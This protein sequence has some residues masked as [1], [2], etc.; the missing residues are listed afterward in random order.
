MKGRRS[1]MPPDAHGGATVPPGR[2]EP[3]PEEP[4]AGKVRLRALRGTKGKR[5]AK[6]LLARLK[7]AKADE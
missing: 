6:E 5:V 7:G 1:E 3:V 2:P 4:G